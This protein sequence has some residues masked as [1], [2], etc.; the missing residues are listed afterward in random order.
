MT[1]TSGG[2]DHP[3]DMPNSDRVWKSVAA[4]RIERSDGAWVRVGFIETA[5]GDLFAAVH[6]PAGEPRGVALICPPPLAEGPRNYRREY[7]L[8]AGLAEGGV[9][10][11]RFHPIGSGQS[12]DGPFT[13]AS[14]SA[15]ASNA[16][17]ALLAEFG[18]LPVAVVGTRLAA[19]VAARTTP[20]GGTL[21]LWD[22]VVDGSAY[23]KEVMR[24][25]R[26][27]ELAS[28]ESSKEEDPSNRIRADNG[29]VDVVG[30]P[31]DRTLLDEATSQ[32]LSEVEN[33]AKRIEIVEMSRK[34]TPRPAV[35]ALAEQ[36]R[37]RGA[38]VRIDTVA[39]A[40]S[41]W[42]GSAGKGGRLEVE[43]TATEAVTLTL[44]FLLGDG[45][46]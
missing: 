32:P 43:V 46:W 38:D 6:G 14:M 8:A 5:T 31:V 11:M 12:G 26:L 42:F 7:Q 30:Y 27:S 22:P 36:W 4:D 23:A 18:D 9:A 39:A 40:E 19:V 33:A 24:A 15:D 44:G 37:G 3:L 21:V 35:L 13:I 45:A 16:L 10:A 2:D 17:G 25:R 29:P 41:W 20:A 1:I 34:G 28:G